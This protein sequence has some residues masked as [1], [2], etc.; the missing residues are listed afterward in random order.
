MGCLTTSPITSS[1]RANL[2][3]ASRLP[4]SRARF[5]LARVYGT[6]MEP[7][8]R[9]RQLLLIR[10][11]VSPS[12]GALVVVQLPPDTRGRP[13]P[14][15]IKRLTHYDADGRAWVESDNQRAPGRVD[16]WTV[17]AL[18]PSTIRGVVIVRLPR[19]GRRGSAP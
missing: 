13:R 10:Y 15:S 17:G 2:H 9:E 16:S 1:G 12:P 18:D 4:V 3:G 19:R 5:G 7:T 11:A 8:L 14:L 6:S